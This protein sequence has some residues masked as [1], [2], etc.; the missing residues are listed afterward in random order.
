M[1]VTMKI[2][3]NGRGASAIW[4]EAITCLRRRILAASIDGPR[5]GLYRR[6]RSA[7]SSRAPDLGTPHHA[8][9]GPPCAPLVPPPCSLVQQP[10]IL[11]GA[12]GGPGAPGRCRLPR[13]ARGRTATI[14]PGGPVGSFAGSHGG[15]FA[16]GLAQAF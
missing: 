2:H 6:M 7:E 14:P 12:P 3:G 9:A 5:Q 10:A 15:A 4:A 8:T 13:W 11:D 16:P 1:V